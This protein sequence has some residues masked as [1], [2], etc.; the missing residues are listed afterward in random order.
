MKTA[1]TSR[2]AF[3][4]PRVLLGFSLYAAGV[5]LALAPMKGAAAGEST[6]MELSP[7]VP[8]HA[9]GRWRATGDL[10]TARAY[11][12]ATL[13]P[14]GQVLVA[15]GIG[16][17]G[18][19]GLASA[20]LYDPTTEVWTVTGSIS[21]ARYYHTMTLLLNGQVLVVSGFSAELYDP[22][23]GVWT[24]TEGPTDSRILHTATLLQNGQVLVAGGFGALS[25]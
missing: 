18:R 22:A 24:T 9:P 16:S 25:A 2:S 13:L 23:T 21:Q 3:F 1:R 15:G 4:N 10:V 7:S 11:H 19:T 8:A 17:D 20:E 5:I 6:D 12:T 14:N